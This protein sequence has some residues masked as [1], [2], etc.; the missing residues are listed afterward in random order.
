M[1]RSKD[2]AENPPPSSADSSVTQWIAGLK[3]GA[4]EAADR[5]WKRYF[6]RLVGLARRKLGTAPRRMA[7]E[8][9]VA[10]IVF[11]N[12]WQGA[13]AGRFPELRN[14]E[15]LWPL[16]V[17]LTSRRVHDLLRYDKRRGRN[18]APDELDYLIAEEPTPE[19]AAMMSENVARLF[20]QLDPVQRQVA[21]G[22]LEGRENAE[23]A[24]QLGRS[25]RTVERKLQLIRRIWDANP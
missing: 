3:E 19:F 23:I 18:G 24:R 13:E 1:I 11:R 7:D 25:E 20:E 8:E 12:L 15:N 14:R 22:K 4:A 5:L 21:Q 2:K 16:L 9:D 17:V 10:A 6:E